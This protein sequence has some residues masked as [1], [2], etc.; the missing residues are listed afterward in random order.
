MRSL[1][2]SNS[3]GEQD[4]LGF[5]NRL[6]DGVVL[7]AAKEIKTGARYVKSIISQLRH[8]GQVPADTLTE[9]LWIFL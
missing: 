3:Y 1:L 4:E 8:L 2:I 9:Y 6:T 5:L 7:N